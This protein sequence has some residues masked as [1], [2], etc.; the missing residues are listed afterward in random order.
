[1][2]IQVIKVIAKSLKWLIKHAIIKNNMIPYKILKSMWITKKLRS[3]ILLK[4]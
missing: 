2:V 3:K 1:M 4:L